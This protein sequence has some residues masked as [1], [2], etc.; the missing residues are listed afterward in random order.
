[1]FENTRVSFEFAKQRTRVFVNIYEKVA[2]T[3]CLSQNAPSVVTKRKKKESMQKLS[4]FTLA[5]VELAKGI[6]SFDR[7]RYNFS[8]YFSSRTNILRLFIRKKKTLLFLS[9]H[10]R[11]A[12]KLLYFKYSIIIGNETIF[13]N[14]VQLKKQFHADNLERQYSDLP[15]LCKIKKTIISSKHRFQVSKFTRRIFRH[16][17]R[18]HN[19]RIRGVPTFCTQSTHSCPLLSSL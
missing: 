9:Q 13:E 1:M 3:I 11:E 10:R 2:G 12:N 4:S 8:K 17:L 5:T 19:H 18:S 7:I 15:S 16:N 14:L 6:W